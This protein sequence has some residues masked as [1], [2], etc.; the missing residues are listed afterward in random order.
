MP[1]VTLVL[2]T[3]MASSMSGLRTQHGDAIEYGS[4]GGGFRHR[5]DGLAAA[6]APEYRDL[7]IV[8][9]EPDAAKADAVDHDGVERLA[10]H[11]LA[12]VRLEVFRLCSEPDDE[13]TRRLVRRYVGDDVGI[14][15]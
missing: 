7:G 8:R 12:A 3:S 10:L 1:N 2:P 14:A 6:T 15:F 9:G 13:T 4:C 11:L 5:P